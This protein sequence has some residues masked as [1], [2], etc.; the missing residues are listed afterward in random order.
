[1][2]QLRFLLGFDLAFCEDWGNYFLLRWI[3]QVVSYLLHANTGKGIPEK[4]KQIKNI[5]TKVPQLTQIKSI[6]IHS[7]LMKSHCATL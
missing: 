4:N 7:G 6:T 1:M 2:E 5:I 3:S